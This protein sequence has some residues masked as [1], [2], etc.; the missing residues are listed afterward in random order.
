MIINFDI[1]DSSL[2][3]PG[4]TRRLFVTLSRKHI[5]SQQEGWWDI[6]CNKLTYDKSMKIHCFNRLFHKETKCFFHIYC[7]LVYPRVTLGCFS[8]P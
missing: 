2:Q 5:G 4:N 8:W 3:C 1:L 6:F 7:M